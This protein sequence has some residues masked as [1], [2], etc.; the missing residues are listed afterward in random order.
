MAQSGM[1][2][3]EVGLL[4]ELINLSPLFLARRNVHEILEREGIEFFT[5][6]EKSGPAYRLDPVK[7]DW[8]VEQARQEAQLRSPSIQATPTES[9]LAACRKAVR[10]DLIEALALSLLRWGR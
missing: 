3:S 2:H 4:G 7:L 9:D 10:R 6:V 1:F 8:V 5:Q